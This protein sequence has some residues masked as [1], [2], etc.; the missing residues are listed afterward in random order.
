ML[1]IR[2]IRSE[3][4]RNLEPVKPRRQTGKV[5]LITFTILSRY[6]QD[7]ETLVGLMSNV[8]MAS[9]LTGFPDLASTRFETGKEYVICFDGGGVTPTIRMSTAVFEIRDKKVFRPS[10]KGVFKESIKEFHDWMKPLI[11]KSE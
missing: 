8:G 6:K 7:P 9:H 3:V 1:R 4:L 2:V 11:V 10:V 5:R